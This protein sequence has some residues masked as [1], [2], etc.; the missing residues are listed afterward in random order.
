MNAGQSHYGRGLII[1]IIRTFEGALKE[2]WGCLKPS[3]LSLHCAPLPEPRYRALQ[4]PLPARPPAGSPSAR[5]G[6][7]RRASWRGKSSARPRNPWRRAFLELPN[8]IPR[9]DPFGRVFALLDPE[10]FAEA[11]SAWT[12]SLRRARPGEVLAL[13]NCGAY[14]L[15]QASQYNG[16]F[17][18]CMILIRENGDTEL[19]RKRDVFDDLIT[20]DLF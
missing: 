7:G 15:A 2:A 18:P 5:S 6:A 9:H 1:T 3:S 12:Q 4:A 11:F 14:T 10:P 13:L 8:A 17:L 16:R 20:N 19:I